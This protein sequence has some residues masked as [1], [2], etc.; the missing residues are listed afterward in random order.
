M[1]EVTYY[2]NFK[3]IPVPDYYLELQANKV[4]IGMDFIF[5]QYAESQ[6]I[7][8]GAL[9]TEEKVQSVTQGKLTTVAEFKEETRALVKQVQ[10]QAQF[11]D[12]IMMFIRTY[13][14]E[15]AK[16]VVD[17]EAMDE[18]I[19]ARRIEVQEQVAEQEMSM[20]TYLAE[21]FDL[22]EDKWST[23]QEVLEEEYIFQHV[24]APQWFVDQGGDYSEIGYDA[25]IQ[26]Q[27]VHQGA[28]ELVVREALSYPKYVENIGAMTYQAVMA[29]YFIPKIKWV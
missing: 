22:S 9:L 15:T 26:H 11:D 13:L 16:Y 27:V 10:A 5:N 6:G 2:P 29:A 4:E 20:D 19:Q 1:N 24:I 23:F 18:Y 8:V 12:A 17:A 3:E 14:V 28:D 21:V 25:Y 7:S